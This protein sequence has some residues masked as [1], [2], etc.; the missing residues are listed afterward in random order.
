MLQITLM[1]CGHCSCYECESLGR[2]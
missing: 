2:S 1:S